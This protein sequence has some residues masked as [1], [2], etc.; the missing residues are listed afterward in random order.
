LSFYNIWGYLLRGGI[1]HRAGSSHIN[2]PS[3]ETKKP[4]TPSPTTTTKNKPKNNNNNNN[5]QSCLQVNEMEAFS[6]LRFLLP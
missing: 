4:K 5:P 3:K 6:Q 1:A 2:H